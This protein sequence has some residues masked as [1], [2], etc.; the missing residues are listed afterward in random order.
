MF[1]LDEI[2]TRVGIVSYGLLEDVLLRREMN[3]WEY[4]SLRYAVGI[5]T[6]FISTNIAHFGL[7]L[8]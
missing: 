2:K 3:D 1:M 6:A 8:L 7:S 5:L 4:E